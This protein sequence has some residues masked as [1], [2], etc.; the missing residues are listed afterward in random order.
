MGK[1]KMWIIIA[2]AAVIWIAMSYNGMLTSGK[3]VDQKWADVETA[4]QAR[5]DK[6]QGLASIVKNAADFEQETLTAVIE[7]RAKAT[8]INISADNLTAENLAQFEQAQAQLKGSLSKLMLVVERYP[9]LQAVQAYRDFQHQYEGIENR[10]ASA[11]VDYNEA[12]TNYNI[13]IKRL[14]NGLYSGMLGFDEKPLFKSNPGSENAP[15]MDD[16]LNRSK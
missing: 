2:I 15:D 5:A 11:R 8:G 13:K 3:K 14:P 10:I 12:A 4:Y 9:E 1:N 16:A 7:A 6:V